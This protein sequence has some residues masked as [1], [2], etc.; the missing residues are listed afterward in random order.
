M[1]SIYDA[2]MDAKAAEASA[3]AAR[4]AIEDQLLE[5]LKIDPASEGVKNIE[6]EG[7]AVKITSR[8]DRKVDAE[9]LQDLAREAGLSEHL[10]SLFRWTPSINLAVWKASAPNIT[11]ALAGAITTKPGRP[12]FAITPADPNP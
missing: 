2:W 7:F 8:L 5:M 4:R 3:I 6:A 9:K 1:D 12:S 11:S 10:S